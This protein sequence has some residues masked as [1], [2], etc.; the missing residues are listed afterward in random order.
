MFRIGRTP[1][2]NRAVECA[3]D[4][5]LDG[6]SKGLL[7]MLKELWP[8]ELVKALGAIRTSPARPIG[9]SSFK[10]LF[11]DE[12]MPLEELQVRSMCIICSEVPEDY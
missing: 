8:E 10:L 4:I 7:G 1:E 5:L 11:G 3:N 6:L 2:A 9:F 12:A